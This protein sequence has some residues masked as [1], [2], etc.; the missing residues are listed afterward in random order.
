MNVMG[1]VFAIA[2]VGVISLAGIIFYLLKV[3]S[4]LEKE[5]ASLQPPF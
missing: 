4:D 5:N 1:V 2:L 3:I